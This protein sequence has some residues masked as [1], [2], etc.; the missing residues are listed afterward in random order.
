M[1]LGDGCLKSKKYPNDKTRYE[2]V[3]C[4]STKQQAYIEYKKKLFH[5]IMGGKE[6][7]LAYG[8]HTINNKTYYSVRFSRLHK[9]FRLF[10][11]VLYCN[12]NKK[13]FSRKVLDYLNPQALAIWYMDDGT[14]SKRKNN[15]GNISSCEMRICTYVTEREADNIVTYFY[16]VWGITAKKRRCKEHQ[17]IIVFNTTESKKFELLI[18]NYIIPEMMYKLPSLWVTRVPDNSI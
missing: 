12:N 8:S 1:M 3:V 13:Y 2:F 14:L 17:Y 7:N 10:H 5:S 6:P 4:H 9:I 15:K 11:K 16:E 18:K